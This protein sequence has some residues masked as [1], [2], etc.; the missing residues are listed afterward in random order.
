[1]RM[2][3]EARLEDSA[4]GSVLVR[5]VEFQRADGEL[6][7]LGLSLAEGKKLVYEAQRDLDDRAYRRRSFGARPGKAERR[8]ANA[9]VHTKPSRRFT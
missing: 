4:G 6:K 2:I 9:V 1:M 5:L 7:Q 8:Q 3:L